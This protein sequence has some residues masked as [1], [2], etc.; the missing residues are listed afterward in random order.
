M[1]LLG[2]NF[3]QI[4]VTPAVVSG[5]AFAPWAEGPRLNP[6]PLH[7]KDILNIVPDDSFDSAQ[8]I[9]MH[10]DLATIPLSKYNMDSIWNKC[11]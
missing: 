9:R 6:W 8:H 4:F 5:T 2:K 1:W 3:F 11:G 10:V 7:N